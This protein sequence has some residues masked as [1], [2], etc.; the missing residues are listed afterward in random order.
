MNPNEFD[1]PGRV[2]LL[3]EQDEP[4]LGH[5][6]G[7]RLGEVLEQGQGQRGQ[8]EVLKS[9]QGDQKEEGFDLQR[10]S[11]GFLKGFIGFLKTC[12]FHRPGIPLS[13]SNCNQ[14]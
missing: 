6:L 12:F 10:A 14:S 3:W 1:D 2:F 4:G 13:D 8:G 7:P 11:K 9:E 5:G